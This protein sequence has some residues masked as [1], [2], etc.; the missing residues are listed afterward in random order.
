MQE[1]GKLFESML[2][3]HCVCYFY[4]GSSYSFSDEMRALLHS[5]ISNLLALRSLEKGICPVG[6]LDL[7]EC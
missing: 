6:N 2:C 7:R 3:S 5:Q 1:D 4:P